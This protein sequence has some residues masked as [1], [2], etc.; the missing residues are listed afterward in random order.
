MIHRRCLTAAVV[1]LALGR[2]S[3]GLAAEGSQ[4]SELFYQLQILQQ[5]ITTLRGT[6]EEQ[7]YQIEQLKRAQSEQYRNV[8][9][10]LLALQQGA[11][12]V[13]R[14]SSAD[15]SAAAAGASAQSGATAA[16]AVSASSDAALTDEQREYN[17]AYALIGEKR[18]DEALRAFNRLIVD[19]PGG[20]LTG[21]ALYWLGELYLA[22]DQTERARAQFIQVLDLYPDHPK[23]PDT[24]FKLGVTYDRLGD[25]YR[26]LEY[27]N[28]VR[29]EHPQHKAAT[30]AAEYA[31]E[32]Q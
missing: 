31:T 10:R 15:Q 13:P 24:L 1:L 19:Y 3:H 22:Q 21:N 26:A 16:P 12:Q 6:V 23:V 29:A 30:L 2:V 20:A 17:A 7:A 9:Q 5:E 11:A 27:L 4:L 32:M 8:D 28:Q 14:Q 18:Y 25:N